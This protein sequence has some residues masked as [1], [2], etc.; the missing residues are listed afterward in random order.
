MNTDQYW[1]IINTARS[2]SDP[3]NQEGMLQCVE[4]R[5]A[6]LTASEIA[7]W[8][9]I[10]QLY[11]TL[12]D[13]KDLEQA[14]SNCGIY[15]SDDSFLYFRGWL[16]SLGKDAFHSILNNPRTLSEHITSTK[17]TRF[18]SFVYVG[19]EVYTKKAFSEEYGPEGMEQWRKKWLADHPDKGEY[20]LDWALSNKYNIWEAS[21]QH[22][23]SEEAK[24]EIRR[25]LFA[26]SENKRIQII[27]ADQPL[28]DIEKKLLDMLPQDSKDYRKLALHLYTGYEWG[29][30]MLPAASQAFHQEMK[31]MFQDAGWEYHEPKFQSACP[32]YSKGK[33]RLYCH[34]LMISGPCETE[35]IGEVCKLA[36]SASTCAI[37]KVEDHGRI[38]DITEEQYYA[39]LDAMRPEIEADL[40]REFAP[41]C[42]SSDSDRHENVMLNYR[43]MTMD[44]HTQSLSSSHPYWAYTEKVLEDLI[45]QG[46]II[47]GPAHDGFSGMRHMTSPEHRIQDHSPLD[48]RLR[49]AA[50]KTNSAPPPAHETKQQPHPE[51]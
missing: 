41:P 40:L 18:E 6:Q 35:L 30:G 33:S 27:Q 12:A 21:H 23:I 8:F 15:L 50:S 51:R 26:V 1:D 14:A 17:D 11:L 13:R 22:P 4:S 36:T 38:F 7:D 32:E 39:A 49:D 2:E 42:R 34:P 37:E 16:L 45:S 46:K 24:E 43:V 31:A 9:N 29:Y 25:D 10:H 28:K 19:N 44:H 20:G 47:G 48:S 3:G 5:L